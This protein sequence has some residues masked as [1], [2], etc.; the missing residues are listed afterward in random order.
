MSKA[1]V[2]IRKSKGRDDDVGLE[3]QRENVHAYAEEHYDEYD[4]LDLGVRSGFS[5]FALGQTEDRLDAD[6]EVESAVDDLRN[7]EYDA[8]VAWNDTRVSRD[9]YFYVVQHACLQGGVEI[10][11]VSD[12]VVDDETVFGV[13]RAA[14]TAVKKKEIRETKRA[15]AARA[16]SDYYQGRPKYGTQYDDAKQYLVPDDDFDDVLTALSM[17]EDGASYSEI[18][19]NTA[20]SGTGTLRNVLDR[21]EF[22]EELASAHERSKSSLVDAKE[23]GNASEIEVT[24]GGD[25]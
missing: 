12:D 23:G 19:E 24:G 1:L 13:M 14:E 16:D 3:L 20:I 21:R 9:E 6:P 15:L 10:E 4:T 25:E 17:R 8:L 5:I 22:Y 11:F 2:W 7:G 18:L